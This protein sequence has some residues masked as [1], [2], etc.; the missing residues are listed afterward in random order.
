MKQ[1]FSIKI[2][3][4][5]VFNNVFNFGWA[6]PLGLQNKC[7]LQSTRLIYS[8]EITFA[9][10]SWLIPLDTAIMYEDNNTWESINPAVC[11]LGL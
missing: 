2:K 8:S 7:L 9:N 4:I 5:V 1:L 10:V 6:V 3:V 11:Q